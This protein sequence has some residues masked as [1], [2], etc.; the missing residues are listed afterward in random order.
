[1]MGKLIT[2]TSAMMAPARSRFC[3]SGITDCKAIKPKYKKNKINTEVN[4]A[5]QI[6]QVPHMGF[7]QME[8]VINASNVN[9]TPIFALHD[10]QIAAI[11]RRKTKVI[12]AEHAMTK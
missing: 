10:M 4:L 8:P 3:C 7:P 6:H 2:P 1:M 9:Q 5:S 12:K 11:L